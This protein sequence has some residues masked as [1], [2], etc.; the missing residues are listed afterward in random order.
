[1]DLIGK[2][3]WND[4]KKLIGEHAHD[5]FS[6]A[7]IIWRRE[8]TDIDRWKEDNAQG[9]TVDIPLECLVNYNYFRSWPITLTT[10]SGETQE[11]SIQVLF[12]KNYLSGIGYLNDDGFFDY[13]P[14]KDLFVLDGLIRRPMGDSSVSQAYDESLMVE[15]IMIEQKTPTGTSR[16]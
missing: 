8:V 11:Q 2:A 14:D 6:K 1:M 10:E 3:N 16:S 13:N 7:I 15:V 9:Q 4:F 12:S 5:T